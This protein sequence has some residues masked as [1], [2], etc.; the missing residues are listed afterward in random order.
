MTTT[1][2]QQ[3]WAALLGATLETWAHQLLYVRHIYPRH[4]FGS[5]LFLGV[6]CKVNR[7]P[8]VI[9]Y[10]RDAVQV[11]VPSLVSGVTDELRLVVTD[12]EAETGKTTELESYSLRLL[13]RV[14]QDDDWNTLSNAAASTAAANNGQLSQIMEQLEKGMRNLVMRVHSLESNRATKSDTVSFQLVL[15]VASQD[16]TCAELDRV[17]SEGTWCSVDASHPGNDHKNQK[18]MRPIYNLSTLFCNMEMTMTK[19]NALGR[20]IYRRKNPPNHD[21]ES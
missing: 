18:S 12:T 19:S 5:S 3:Q 16:A 14:V 15:H 9:S 2:L 4:S 20:A 17:F 7:H 11:A 6:R 1:T 21:W 8:D 10:I 13:G